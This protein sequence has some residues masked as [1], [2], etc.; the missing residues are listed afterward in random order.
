MLPDA[1]LQLMAQRVEFGHAGFDQLEL[2]LQQL[3]DGAHVSRGLDPGAYSR[4]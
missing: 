4:L 1:L 3:R 2:V